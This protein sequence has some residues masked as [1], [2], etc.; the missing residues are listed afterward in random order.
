MFKRIFSRAN[1][2]IYL[3]KDEFAFLVDLGMRRLSQFCNI[4]EDFGTDLE[5]TKCGYGRRGLKY[6]S[7]DIGGVVI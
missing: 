5:I 6:A 3:H 4:D 1:E 7:S 2:T